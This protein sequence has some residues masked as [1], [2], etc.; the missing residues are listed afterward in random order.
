MPIAKQ[1]HVVEQTDEKHLEMLARDD[2]QAPSRV[3]SAWR[4]AGAHYG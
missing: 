3:G 4:R 1:I 2:V